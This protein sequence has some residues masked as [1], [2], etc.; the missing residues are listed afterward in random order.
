MADLRHARRPLLAAAGAT[1]ALLV[2]VLLAACGGGT[3]SDDPL[4]GYWTGGDAATPVLVHI[5]KDGETYSVRANPDTPLGDAVKNGEA[6]VVDTHAVMMTLAPATGDTLTV[7]LSGEAFKRERVLTLR[8][9]DE[10][11]YADAAVK[12][13][14]AAIRRGLM[15][16]A[17]GGGKEF[18]P[19][20]EVSADGLLGKMVSPWPTN[21]FAGRPMQPGDGKGDYTYTP[22]GGGKRF[23]LVG[24]LS[25]GSTTTGQ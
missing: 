1:V 18:P 19:P 7:T 21:M 2:A 6:L 23:T 3:A 17:G 12:Y 9:V 4:V 8:R 15:M 14:I 13:G 11:Q 24:H 22:T 20:Q 5:A 16:W 10:D 25:D